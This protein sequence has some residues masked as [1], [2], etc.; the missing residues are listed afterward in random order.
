MT[1]VPS[2]KEKVMNTI[3]TPGTCIIYPK[4]NETLSTVKGNK[5]K[6]NIKMFENASKG[7][8]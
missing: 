4:M 2:F 7:K 1:H 8:G 6:W 3:N 5:K